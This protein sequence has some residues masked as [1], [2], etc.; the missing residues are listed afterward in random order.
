MASKRPVHKHF[1]SSEK[2]VLHLFNFSMHEFERRSSDSDNAGIKPLHP[3]QSGFSE[4]E[5]FFNGLLSPS[6]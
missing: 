6:R 5:P 4:K 1:Y 2:Q 3:S